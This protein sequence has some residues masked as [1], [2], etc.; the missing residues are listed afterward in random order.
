MLGFEICCKLCLRF[1]LWK[2]VAAKRTPKGKTFVIVQIKE[3]IVVKGNKRK[4]EGRE[5]VSGKSGKASRA[6]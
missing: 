1:F 3:K 6:I 4:R 5:L 2:F